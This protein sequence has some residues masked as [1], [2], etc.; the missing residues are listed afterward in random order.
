MRV[1][2]SLKT[3]TVGLLLT[4]A[5]TAFAGEWQTF[6]QAAFDEAKAQGKTVVLDFHADWCSTC[7]KQKP[8]L[9]GL[10]K[11]PSM[12]SVVGFTVD[13][14]KATELKTTMKVQKQSTLIVFKGS[15]EVA[16]QMGLTSR[17]EIKALFTKGI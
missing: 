2:Q 16:R 17:D 3:L 9:E 5:T 6:N 4:F 15:N 1:F 13:F 8:I 10:L 7:K 11:E 12:S 14:D